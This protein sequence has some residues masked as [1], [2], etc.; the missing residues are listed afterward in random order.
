MIE[1]TPAARTR[2][3][4]GVSPLDRT[5]VPELA[6]LSF[7]VFAHPAGRWTRKPLAVAISPT[8]TGALGVIVSRSLGFSIRLHIPAALAISLLPFVMPYP[9]WLYPLSV[10][11]GAGLAVSFYRAHGLV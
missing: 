3:H 5:S 8:A 4:P 1:A 7:E 6:A 2:A 10:G 11:I 9:T